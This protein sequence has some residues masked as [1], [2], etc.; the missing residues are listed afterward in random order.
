MVK[1]LAKDVN[2]AEVGNVCV[3]L[4]KAAV[5]IGSSR[6]AWIQSL[7]VVCRDTIV[8]LQK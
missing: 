6:R 8:A 2:G 1:G 5:L 4:K 3:R 7:G